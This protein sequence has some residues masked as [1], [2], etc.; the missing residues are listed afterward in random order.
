MRVEMRDAAGCRAFGEPRQ[1]VTCISMA[2]SDSP[3][4]F[5][6]R[7][8]DIVFT[9]MYRNVMNAQPNLRRRRLVASLATAATATTT[10]LA[11][12]AWSSQPVRIGLTPVFL[13]DR[14]GFLGRFR[15]YLEAALAR[16]VTFVQRRSYADIVEQLLNGS[17]TAAWLCGYPFVRYRS[18]MQ[19]IAVPVYQGNPTY[20]SYIISGPTALDAKRF[21]DL[22]GKV[23]AYS[24]P[25]SN[26][27][28]L[29]TQDQL[30]TLAQRDGTFFRKSF[31]TFAHQNVVAAVAAG[32]ADAGSVDGY[33]WDSLQALN[34]S[35]TAN[36]R[37]VLKSG[38][39]GFPP[40]VSSKR[41]ERGL[42]E[43]V[44]AAFVDM[45]RSEPGRELLRD[46]RLDSFVPG[47]PA[48]FDGVAAM[49]LRVGS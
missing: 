30:R 1:F 19:L 7:R 15:T 17:L 22:R 42:Q 11:L 45:N 23:F 27:G 12:P 6:Y 41:I 3:V 25:L 29:F 2:N 34:P 26:S 37:I 39:F 24:D 40:F 10:G 46:L 47:Q 28:F 16:P 20:R 14:A 8:L 13:D 5:R 49:M 21:A 48:L 31:F 18:V 38:P 44:R 36:T 32:L 35:L 4:T 9:S 33:V 43:K